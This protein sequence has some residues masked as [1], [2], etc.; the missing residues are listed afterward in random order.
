MTDHNDSIRIAARLRE[1]VIGKSAAAEEALREHAFMELYGG[2][3]HTTHE[4]RFKNILQSGEILPE[5]NVPDSERWSTSAGKDAYPYARSIGG[6][7]IVDFDRFNREAY[8]R[9]YP[10]SSW[11]TFVPYRAEWGHSVWIEIDRI[12]IASK[13]ISGLE[14]L[15]RW[16]S[17]GAH[18][19]RIMPEIEA[20]HI[21]PIPRAAFKRAFLVR[22]DNIQI[23]PLSI[24]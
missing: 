21:G 8:S 5:P 9:K 22:A 7:S 1:A 14:L 15:T 4:E 24:V 19:H 6:V 2:V 18:S 23:L 11:A 20:A 13:F 16:N 17:E 3:W 10:S 12:Q